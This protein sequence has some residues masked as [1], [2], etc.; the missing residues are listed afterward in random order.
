VVGLR[1]WLK[2]L[3]RAAEEEMIVIPQRDGTVKRFPAS[4]GVDAYMNLMERLG[5]GED[6]PPEHPLIAAA[7]NSTEPKWAASFYAV[8]DPEE[9]TRP[10]EDLSES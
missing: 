4:A 3:E 9:L 6:A 10:V 7:R 1:G 2:R 5:A 8:N